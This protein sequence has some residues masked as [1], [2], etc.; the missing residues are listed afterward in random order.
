MS[1]LD[2]E[3][4]APGA[5]WPDEVRQAVLQCDVLLALIHSGWHADQVADGSGEKALTQADDW[6]R[7]EI[8]TALQANKIVIPLLIDGAYLN[9]IGADPHHKNL[10]QKVWLP[11]DLHDLFAGQDFG[12]RFDDL[13]PHRL[14]DFLSHLR[15]HLPERWQ[16]TERPRGEHVAGYYP[17]VL[18]ENFPLTREVLS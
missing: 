17:G 14:N 18:Q 6:V 1:F 5:K 3:S 16:Q 11:A 13:T 8:A 12:L 4:I 10:P 2:D 15:T 9:P 7:Q